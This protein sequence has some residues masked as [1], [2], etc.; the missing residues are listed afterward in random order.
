MI[1]TLNLNK[2]LFSI[3]RYKTLNDVRHLSDQSQC[4]S[5]LTGVGMSSTD[6]I[7]MQSLIL[8]MRSIKRVYKSR[9]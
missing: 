1:L 7:L 2:E 8:S 3:A 6:F 4:Y 5:K 9:N